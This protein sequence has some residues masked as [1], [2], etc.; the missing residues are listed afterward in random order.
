MLGAKE[1]GGRPLSGSPLFS[2]D[3]LC[4][5]MAVLFRLTIPKR[6]VK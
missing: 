2:S 1:E 3:T 6:E 4:G 5:S